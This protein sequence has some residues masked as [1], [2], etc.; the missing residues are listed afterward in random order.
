ML[1]KWLKVLEVLNVLK[2]RKMKFQVFFFWI[3]WEKGGV[4]GR[5]E[6]W[7]FFIISLLFNNS[8]G[9]LIVFLPSYI[10]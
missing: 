7:V 2:D 6:C 4:K 3:W 10:I 1:L 9:G 8:D 5:R